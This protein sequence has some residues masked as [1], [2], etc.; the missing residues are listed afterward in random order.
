MPSDDLD[1]RFHR[2]VYSIINDFNL[3]DLNLGLCISFMHSVEDPKSAY[4]RIER[5][6][7]SQKLEELDGLTTSLT[8]HA[9]YQNWTTQALEIRDLRNQAAH[10]VWERYLPTIE[11]P[12][13]LRMPPWAQGNTTK[14]SIEQLEA[15]AAEVHHIFETFQAWRRKHEVWG[16]ESPPN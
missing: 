14:F 5:M 3:L 15:K 9:D 12:I 11:Q 8:C 1:S 4:R 7:F 13:G 2:A 6:S 10:G 16:I